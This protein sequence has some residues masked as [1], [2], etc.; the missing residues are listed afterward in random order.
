MAETK[1]GIIGVG[2]V[3]TEHLRALQGHESIRV[4]GIAEEMEELR[5]ARA[6]E[7]EV[8]SF[9]DHIALLEQARP[10]YV[11]VCTPHFSHID[12]ACDAM[13]RGVHVL[14]EKPLTVR[15]SDGQ[16]GLEVM[17]ETGMIMGVG[18][19]LRLHATYARLHDLV[20]SGFV[21]EVIRVTLVRTRWFRSMAYYRSSSWRA[22]WKGEGGGILVNQ[23]PHD[24]DMMIWVVGLPSQVLAE[25][26]TLGHDI[27]VEDDVC[28]L[29]KWANGATGTMHVCTN[30][31][32]GRSF[33]EIAGTKG[34]LLLEDNCLKATGLKVD[35]REF[36]QTATGLFDAPPVAAITSYTEVSGENGYRLENENFAAAIRG[37]AELMCP[38]E[39]A[40]KEVQLANALLVS[41]VKQE[42]VEV[43]GDP[44]EYDQI[45]EELM[46]AGSLRAFKSSHR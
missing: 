43:P 41:G 38:A 26:N 10:D 11:V 42:W 7:Y 40:L 3:G 37:E 36:S 39:E 45:L 4:V 29:M 22:T 28:A 17:R 27:E 34:T 18:F 9:P 32:P 46:R 33:F 14:V 2:V 21:G 20:R 15:A 25:L 12:I 13:R 30:E 23:A 24:L 44:Q 6:Q 19:L 16:R 1:V 35:S 8:P 5:T 31:A